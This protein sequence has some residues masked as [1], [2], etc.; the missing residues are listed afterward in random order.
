MA[1]PLLFNT[2]FER[3]LYGCMQ[4]SFICFY[5]WIVSSRVNI[6]HS[7]SHSPQAPLGD[8][9]L[10]AVFCYDGAAVTV[11]VHGQKFLSGEFLRMELLGK[12]PAN[13]QLI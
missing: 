6:S 1:C 9:G 5:C 3:H 7:M 13:S 8:I 10:V 2:V 4:L 12:G 11:L